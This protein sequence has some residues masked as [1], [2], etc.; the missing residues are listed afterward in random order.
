M[1]REPLSPRSAGFVV[2]ASNSSLRLVDAD[3][4]NFRDAKGSFAGGSV[5]EQEG[6]ENVAPPAASAVAKKRRGLMFRLKLRGKARSTA[7][8]RGKHKNEQATGQSLVTTD[9]GRGENDQATSHSTTITAKP[10]YMQTS[11]DASSDTPKS[12][13]LAGS[14]ERNGIDTT[15]VVTELATSHLS[16]TEDLSPMDPS[17]DQSQSSNTTKPSTASSSDPPKPSSTAASKE[18]VSVFPIKRRHA[19]RT[20]LSSPQGEKSFKWIASIDTDAR[21]V[22]NV[23]KDDVVVLEKT[24]K[25]DG[26]PTVTEAL[27]ANVKKDDVIVLEKTNKQDGALTVTEA[28]CWSQATRAFMACGTLALFAPEAKDTATVDCDQIE[29]IDKYHQQAIVHRDIPRARSCP[30]T[31]HDLRT[32][33]SLIGGL[34]LS[35]D[36]R[37]NAEI[38]CTHWAEFCADKAANARDGLT[39]RFMKT[40]PCTDEILNF[41]VEM[42]E[43]APEEARKS[44]GQATARIDELLQQL[45]EMKSV[46]CQDEFKL[47][48]EA[49]TQAHA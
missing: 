40:G 49:A 13:S 33:A 37:Q 17:R 4:R 39:R 26:A 35:A 6:D 19:K 43:R 34:D 46:T 23:K 7:T 12:S 9:N 22:A 31:S 16:S 1:K 28:S 11:A 24:N 20:L 30:A 41:L 3:V 15:A 29:K 48:E 47:K 14:A 42:K 32:S 36:V 38:Q 21:D 18:S 8:G 44:I 25:Q 45:T 27:V 2:D 5:P 10:A